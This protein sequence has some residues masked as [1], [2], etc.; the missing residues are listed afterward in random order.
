MNQFDK[1]RLVFSSAQ[2]HQ[3]Y[4]TVITYQSKGL[5]EN[6]EPLLVCQSPRADYQRNLVRFQPGVV[7]AVSD[8]R[9]RF[10]HLDRVIDDADELAWNTV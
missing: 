2:Y 9:S 8:P 4:W 3:A 5:Q 7:V 10:E 6:V 1:P